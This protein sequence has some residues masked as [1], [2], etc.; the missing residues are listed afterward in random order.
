MRGKSPSRKQFL[1]RCDSEKRL[2]E[3]WDEGLKTERRKTDLPIGII[4]VV[5]FLE[6]DVSR[7]S[8]SGDHN[9]VQVRSQNDENASVSLH[10]DNSLTRS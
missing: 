4:R 9:S 10:R 1:R 8:L 2:L 5:I 6:N 3:R 7:V